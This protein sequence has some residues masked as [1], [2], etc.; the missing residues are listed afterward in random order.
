MRGYLY[1]SNGII[2]VT[3]AR[4]QGLLFTSPFIQNNTAFRQQVLSVFPN[5][6]AFPSILRYIIR[7]LYPPIFDGSQAQNYTNQIARADALT[8]ELIFT[9]NTFYL[10]TAYNNETYAY[11]FTVPPALHGQDIPY[12]YFN[13]PDP[14]NVPNPR[15]AIALQE[16]ITSFAMDG[17][18]NERGVPFF[19][20]Y[21]NDATVQE[22]SATGIDQLRDPTANAR[23][24]WWQKGLFQ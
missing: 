12:T 15:I 17:N 11:Y 13:G 4:L 19:P 10:D 23:C 3:N 18:P 16:Y 7:T 8:S 1:N 5:L 2:D 6:V 14:E 20:M 9:C 21:G 24:V 22:L